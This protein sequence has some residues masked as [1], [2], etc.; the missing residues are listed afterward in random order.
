MHFARF[1]SF[2]VVVHLACVTCSVDLTI[3]HPCMKSPCGPYSQCHSIDNRAVCSCLSGYFGKPPY[4][5]PEC[6]SSSD[7]PRDKSCSNQF[8]IDPCPGICGYNARCQVVNHSPV[9]NCKNGYTGDPFVRCVLEYESKISA[10]R[11]TNPI[12]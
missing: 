9:C 5:H 2:F 4:C 10:E 3:R 6:I 7:C 8:C 12:L 11:L 1:F